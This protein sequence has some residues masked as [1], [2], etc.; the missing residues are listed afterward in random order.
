[1]N[2][3]QDFDLATLFVHFVDDDVRRVDKLA[4]PFVA[5]WTSHMSDTLGK[6][7]ANLLTNAANDLCGRAWIIPFD[8][9]KYA[10]EIVVGLLP[11]D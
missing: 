4:C 9:L 5:T 11:D 6:Q 1:M 7:K 8:P 10:V 2:N 3:R